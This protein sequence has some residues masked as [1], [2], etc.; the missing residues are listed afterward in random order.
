MTLSCVTFI[1]LIEVPLVAVNHLYV[2]RSQSR[3]KQSSHCRSTQSLASNVRISQGSIFFQRVGAYCAVGGSP[4]LEEVNLSVVRFFASMLPNPSSSGFLRFLRKFSLREGMHP[5]RDTE[6]V[7]AIIVLHR[8][9]SAWAKESHQG[10]YDQGSFGTLVLLW[11]ILRTRPRQT[12]SSSH[13][14][15]KLESKTKNL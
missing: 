3:G 13:L 7:E 10:T 2:W 6:T 4:E 9:P 11:T 14:S 15:K 5:V 1:L 12:R 8:F